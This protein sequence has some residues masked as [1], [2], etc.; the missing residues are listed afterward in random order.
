[1]IKREVVEWKYIRSE[2]VNV[3]GITRF[4]HHAS[5]L[6]CSNYARQTLPLDELFFSHMGIEERKRGIWCSSKTCSTSRKKAMSAHPDRSPL[7]RV[8][9]RCFTSLIATQRDQAK[10]NDKRSMLL[11]QNLFPRCSRHTSGN[12]SPSM[13]SIDDPQK[14]RC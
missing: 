10:W 6:F 9:Y 5:G 2:K 8:R 1:M 13:L 3:S 14:S 11:L 4:I 7:T 12:I